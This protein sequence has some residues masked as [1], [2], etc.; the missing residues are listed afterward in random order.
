MPDMKCTLVKV[1]VVVVLSFMCLEVQIQLPC[2]DKY[3]CLNLKF[4]GFVSYLMFPHHIST[5]FLQC[6]I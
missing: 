2:R 4:S 3:G 6:R 1:E 5:I